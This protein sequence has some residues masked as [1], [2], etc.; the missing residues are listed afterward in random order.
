M[1]KLT[2]RP[3]CKALEAHYTAIHTRHLRELFD[4]DPSR[5]TRFSAEAA[6]LYLD[7]SKNRITEETVRLLVAQPPDG[8]HIVIGRDPQHGPNLASS[9]KACDV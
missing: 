1:S 7:Y 8:V 5:G 9:R 4:Q 2:E 6:G 3:A